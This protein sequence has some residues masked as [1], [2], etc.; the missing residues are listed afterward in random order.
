MSGGYFDYDDYKIEW[1]ADS[2]KKVIESN[3]DEQKYTHETIAKMKEAYYTLLKAKMMT[4]RIDYLL[5]SDDSE[6]SFNERWN[7]ELKALKGE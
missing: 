7:N 5:E 1:I 3:D 2:I 6:E 4:H